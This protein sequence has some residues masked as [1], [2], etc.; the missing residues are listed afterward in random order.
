MKASLFL[1]ASGA[2]LAMAKPLDKRVLE[3]ETVTDI[4]YVTVT[5]GIPVPAP[6]KSIINGGQHTTAAPPP[7]PPPPTTVAPPPPPPTTSAAPPPPP[8]APTPEPEPTPEVKP[9]AVQQ[10]QFVPEPAKEEPAPQPAAQV[11]AQAPTD[12]AS[13]V[14]YHHNVHRENHSAPSMTYG[15]EYAGYAAQSAKSCKFAHDLSPG[16]GKYGQNIAM[17]AATGDVESKGAAAIAA[18]AITDM[19][20]NG[21]INLYPSS[22][23]GQSSPDMGGFE[24]W[25]HYSQVIWKGSNTVGCAAQYC[26]PGTMFDGMGAWFTVCNYFPAGNMGG[27]HGDNVLKPLGK[28]TVTA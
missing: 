3:I 11:Q 28:M 23:Y 5:D 22:G 20:Y 12:F 4:V 9:V 16:G 13:T 21:E 19:W 6:T 26:P 14:L 1:V 25:G 8:P 2:L 17:Y 15:D 18:Q 7:P 24:G 10:Q 27:G